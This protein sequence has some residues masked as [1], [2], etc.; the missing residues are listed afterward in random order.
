[1]FI[2]SFISQ[3]PKDPMTQYFVLLP[4]D[5]MHALVHSQ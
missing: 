1:M 2:I 5:I 4:W 3:N